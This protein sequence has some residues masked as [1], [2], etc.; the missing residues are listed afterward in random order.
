MGTATASL[1]VVNVLPSATTPVTLT[2]NEGQTHTGYRPFSDSGPADTCAATVDSGD[3]SEVQTLALNSNRTFA[4]SHT[5][6]MKAATPSPS[7]LRT[8]T[9]G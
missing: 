8:G 5:T 6:S 9:V 3:G 7:K 4:L 2:L 1:V